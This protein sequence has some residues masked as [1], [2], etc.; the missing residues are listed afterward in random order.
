MASL[1]V[2][3]LFLGALAYVRTGAAADPTVPGAASLLLGTGGDAKTPAAGAPAWPVEELGP[4]K[5]IGLLLRRSNESHTRRPVILIP[6]FFG[7]RL[8]GKRMSPKTVKGEN[9]TSNYVCPARTEWY[10]AFLSYAALD[11]AV[12]FCM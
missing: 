8:R 9:G 2:L 7:T 1:L 5:A 3:L 11:P 10:T 12:A 6:P 4:A